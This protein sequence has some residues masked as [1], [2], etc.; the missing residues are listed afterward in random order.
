[1]ARMSHGR[2]RLRRERRPT[3]S[4]YHLGAPEEPN[5][6]PARAL[7]LSLSGPFGGKRASSNLIGRSLWLC[8]KSGRRLMLSPVWPLE[9]TCCLFIFNLLLFSS[10][11][12]FFFLLPNLLL[13]LPFFAP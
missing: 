10:F 7:S 3:P 4:N 9:Q 12:L 1:M 6:S 2:R 11:F 13:F 5:L 8:F